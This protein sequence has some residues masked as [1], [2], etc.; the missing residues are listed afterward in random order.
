M[1]PADYPNPAVIE[2]PYQQNP[3]NTN[4][5]IYQQPIPF[6][7]MQ[8]FSNYLYSVSIFLLLT[9]KAKASIF[10]M[11]IQPAQMSWLTQQLM[12]QYGPGGMQ[13]AL[14][15]AGLIPNAAPLNVTN[16]LGQPDGQLNSTPGQS[17]SNQ[18]LA[19]AQAPRTAQPQVN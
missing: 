15:L 5:P 7:P 14:H 18:N 6:K 3:S 2:Q 19:A 10:S 12:Q 11:C 16:N 17:L 9:V 1:N 4:N 8:S 13:T